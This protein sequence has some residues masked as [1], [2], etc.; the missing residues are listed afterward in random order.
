MPADIFDLMKDAGFEFDTENSENLLRFKNG[1]GS[2][3]QFFGWADFVFWAEKYF[4]S[5]VIF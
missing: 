5:E 4:D 3:M 2:V 1:N